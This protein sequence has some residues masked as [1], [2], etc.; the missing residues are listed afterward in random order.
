MHAYTYTHAC[1][2]AHTRTYT[3]EVQRSNSSCLWEI[4]RGIDGRVEMR[5]RDG[6]GG[7]CRGG[8]AN[9]VCFFMLNSLGCVRPH[10][11][12]W[13][14]SEE[15]KVFLRYASLPPEENVQGFMDHTALFLLWLH[16][17]TAE[18]RRRDTNGHSSI[19]S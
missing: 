14:F 1:S 12:H 16:K 4:A 10:E 19:G 15:N 11:S 9:Y 7:T 18:G 2:H 13:Q 5:Q 8:R 3:K 6:G 17:S